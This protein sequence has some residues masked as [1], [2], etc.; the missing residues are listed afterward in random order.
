MTPACKSFRER[1]EEALAGRL[2]AS[3]LQRLEW[4]EHLRACVDCR[5]LLESEQALELL[6]ASLPEPRLPREVAERILARLRAARG[7]DRLDA[8]LEL[9]RA[10]DAPE[11]LARR[12][13]TGLAGERARSRTGSATGAATDVDARLD[14]L[15]D[16]ALL[17]VGVPVGLGARVAGRLA[18][19]RPS[20]PVTHWAVLRLAATILVLLGAASA[21]WRFTR[22]SEGQPEIVQAPPERAL[23]ESS[24][25]PDARGVP[26][27]LLASLDLLESWDALEAAGAFAGDELADL[28]PS[29]LLVLE[30][31]REA[32]Q[33][34]GLVLEGQ[35]DG[36]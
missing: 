29:D 7:G 2:E 27:D 9:D 18:Q 33:E 28:E 36:R 24:P 17:D 21:L 25:A 26:D 5:A 1:L 4:H 14:R 31:L 34:L 30:L 13:L 3:G 12:V 23:D 22:P 6:L 35:E 11:D 20:S 32:E 15:L 16:L 8:L 10:Q 19:Q